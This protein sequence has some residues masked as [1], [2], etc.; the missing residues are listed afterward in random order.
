LMNE[1]TN[2]LLGGRKFNYQ[3]KLT[4]NRGI[5]IMRDP[6]LGQIVQS[7]QLA[8]YL[9][10]KKKARIQEPKS[11][12]LIGVVDESGL[13]EENEIFVQIRIDSFSMKACRVQT[14]LSFESPILEEE[15]LE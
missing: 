1:L 13:L 14:D 6:M 11:C 12:T 4:I 5:D 10:I 9:S 8:N 2:G 7:L 15:G 3:L